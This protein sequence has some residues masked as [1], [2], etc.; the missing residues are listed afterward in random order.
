MQMLL[1]GR[2]NSWRQLVSNLSEKFCICLER[3]ARLA[4][5]LALRVRLGVAQ[6]GRP[7]QLIVQRFSRVRVRLRVRDVRHLQAVAGILV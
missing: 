2:F 3:W 4:L 1:G 6:V 5:S 7:V